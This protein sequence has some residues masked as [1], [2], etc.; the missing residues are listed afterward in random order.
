MSIDQK[1]LVFTLAVAAC[2]A[3]I[4]YDS[5]IRHRASEASLAN[6]TIEGDEL[7]DLYMDWMAKARAAMAE[8]EDLPAAER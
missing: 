1:Q 5:L 7:D 2:K 4:K 8:Y 6:P 3:A